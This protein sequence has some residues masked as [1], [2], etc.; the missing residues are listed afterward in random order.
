MCVF[1]IIFWREFQIYET[2]QFWIFGWKFKWTRAGS[3]AVRRGFLT[4]SLS[5]SLSRSNFFTT[6]SWWHL[7]QL[8]FWYLSWKVAFWHI[9]ILT[10]GHID[11]LTCSHTD[12]RT[13]WHTEILFSDILL[14]FWTT[15]LLITK[16]RIDLKFWLFHYYLF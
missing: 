10:Y 1:L 8:S 16:L 13:Y 9:D 15:F 11:I 12:I 6:F 14:T 2:E 5:H 4:L 7:E 3:L